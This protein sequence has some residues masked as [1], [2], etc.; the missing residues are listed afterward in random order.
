MDRELTPKQQTS[1]A[2]RQAESILILTGQHP[3]VDQVAS[4]IALSAILH[5]FG[6]KTTAVIT[7]DLPAGVKFLP[8]DLIEPKLDGLR[9]F[10]MQVDLSRSEV[11]KIKYTI[12]NNK[13]NV[14]VTPFSGGFRNSDVSFAYG[15]FHFD[16]VIVLGVASYSRV[17]RVLAQNQQVLTNVPIIN[18]DFHRSNEQY[19]AI[20]LVETT[21]ASLSEILIALSESLQTGLVDGPIATAMLAGII[22]STDRFT[23]A[24]TTPKALTVA[25]QMM[26]MGADQQQVIRGLYRDNK[27]QKSDKPQQHEAKKEAPKQE[28]RRSEATP[29][30]VKQAE[31][32]TEVISQ[33]PEIAPVP[34]PITNPVTREHSAAISEIASSQVLRN[35]EASSVAEPV[36][37]LQFPEVDQ[38][39]TAVV[40]T[41]PVMEQ[42]L[43]P[44]HIEMDDEPETP[45]VHPEQIALSDDPEP[46]IND[47]PAEESASRQT[48]VRNPLESPTS[49]GRIVQRK[50]SNP[51]NNP[52]FAMR[53]E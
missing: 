45:Q 3:S 11:D 19:G 48:K 31:P 34:E 8:T 26:A 33:V 32:V 53:L 42:L 30:P 43:P 7:D 14:H 36:A 28:M 47:A 22:A 51:A 29:E 16:L 17:D 52:L 20:N 44:T 13:L 50:A 12:E 39:E 21:A 15:D 4:T 1:E 46:L 27:S 2:I 24:H 18:I 23:A 37:E 5:K 49:E 35:D 40:S 6:K 38:R 10:I 25:A 41:E 9:D